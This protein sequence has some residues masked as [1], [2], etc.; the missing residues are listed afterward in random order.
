M[1]T[2]LRLA[3]VLLG[4]GL[5]VLIALGAI[6]MMAPAAPKPPAA[7]ARTAEFLSPYD[8]PTASAEDALARTRTQPDD[9]AAWR[10]LGNA[11]LK[12][13]KFR[14][15]ERS[16]AKAVALDPGRSETWSALGEARIQFE[17]SDGLR[18][19]A[20]AAEAFRKAL[21]LNPRDPRARFYFAME[22]DFTG[23]HDAA[24]GEWLQLLREV[25]AGSDADESI[26]AA[27]TASVSRNQK[28]IA[29]AMQRAI[30]EQPRKAGN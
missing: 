1:K 13:R 12:A 3:L 23:Q 6:R 18:L 24:I 4:L 22:K 16:Y 2:A 27:I 29:R 15:A 20:G 26:R 7:A 5:I 21:A 8:A 9:A 14:D 11:Q 19:P 28:L 10:D 25:P 17:G 30:A